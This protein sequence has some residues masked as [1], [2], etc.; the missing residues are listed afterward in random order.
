MEATA[1]SMAFIVAARRTALG[2]AGGLHRARRIADLTAPVVAA[3]LADS[4]VSA[5]QVDEIIIGSTTQGGNPARLIALAAGLPDSVPAST[6]DSMCGSGLGAILAAVRA[7]ALGE[8]SAVVAG[9]ADSVSTAPWRVAK[10]RT[11][12]QLPVFIGLEPGSPDSEETNRRFEAGEALSRRMQITRRQQDD[13]ALQS[14]AKAET[15][16]SERRFVGEIVPL[17]GNVDELRDESAAGANAD[18]LG[19]LPAFLPPE[20]TLTAGNT[21]ALHDGAAIV[22]AVNE[23]RWRELGSPPALRLVASAVLGVEPSEEAAAPIAAMQKLYGRLNGFDR[24]AIKLVEINESSAAQAIAFGTTLGFAED[25]VNPDGGA[26]VRGH[27]FGAAGAVLVTR[28]FTRMARAPNGACPRY[29]VA[30]L[31]AMGGLGMAALFEAV[32]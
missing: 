10:P 4:K 9:G 27:P 23:A 19:R 2:R 13:W 21:S 16:R 32:H 31:G 11:L 12:H 20:G 8:A 24:G 3:A 15:A 25:V 14:H 18:E 28:L 30:A 22:V 17:R 1:G 7:I 29:G 26:T 5:D 6:V